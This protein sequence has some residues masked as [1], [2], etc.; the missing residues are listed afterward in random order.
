MEYFEWN[1]WKYMNKK[2]IA[3]MYSLE[4][5]EQEEFNCDVGKIEWD[6]YL[7]NYARGLQIYA[8]K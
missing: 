8:L 7:K 1:C 5:E 3:I 2:S 6:S 4:P